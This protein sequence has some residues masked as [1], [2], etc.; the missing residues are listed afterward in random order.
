MK[1]FL[2]A[3]VE[4]IAR[5]HTAILSLNDAYEYNFSDKQLH[6]LV[7]GLFGL[8]LIMLIQPIFNALAKSDH[9]IAITW[10]YVFTVII[11]LTFAIEIGQGLTGTGS[12]D[13]ADI[14]SGVWGFFVIS[15]AFVLIRAIVRTIARL[16]RG[17]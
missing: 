16:I 12:M 4:F 17:E 8:A 10:I 7:I 14:V 11:V 15:F 2:Y 1:A 3:I 6:F 5:I 13:F 9:V